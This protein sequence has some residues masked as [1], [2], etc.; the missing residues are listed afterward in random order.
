MTLVLLHICHKCDKSGIVWWS[1][2]FGIQ[3]TIL[4]LIVAVSVLHHEPWCSKPA[5]D[6]FHDKFSHVLILKQEILQDI[7]GRR[8]QVPVVQFEWVEGSS[9]T[10]LC[11]PFCVVKSTQAHVESTYDP[12]VLSAVEIYKI[13]LLTQSHV[14]VSDFKQT[15]ACLA[16]DVLTL[17][18]SFPYLLLGSHF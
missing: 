3:G 11:W 14:N 9:S 17:N 16:F 8:F 5:L 4:M 6:N 7:P 10:C 15:C 18:S 1:A 12:E 2:E 13:Y